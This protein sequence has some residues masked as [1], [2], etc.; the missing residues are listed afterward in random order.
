[1]KAVKKPSLEAESRDKRRVMLKSTVNYTHSNPRRAAPPSFSQNPNF[2]EIPSWGEE[3]GGTHLYEPA[4]TTTKP[5]RTTQTTGASWHTPRA[6]T[7][8]PARRA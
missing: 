4:A 8:G 7:A 1:M 6:I 5:K 2:S 3:N